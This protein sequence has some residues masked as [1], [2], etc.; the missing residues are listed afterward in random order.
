[1]SMAHC[2][3]PYGDAEVVLAVSFVINSLILS[4]KI[5]NL[6]IKH[7]FASINNKLISIW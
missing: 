6:L 2:I 3:D 7:L 1:L 4:Y 5:L